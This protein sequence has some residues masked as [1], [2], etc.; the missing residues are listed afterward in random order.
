MFPFSDLDD[1]Q[2]FL[3]VLGKSDF[4]SEDVLLIPSKDISKFTTQC[5]TISESFEKDEDENFPVRIESKYYDIN[6]LNLTKPDLPS[7]FGLFHVNIASLN[8]H[9]DDLKLILSL[10]NYKFDVIG[11]SEHKI[12]KHDDPLAN[13]DIP[14]YHSFLFEPT[15]T[16][17]GGTGFYLK[18]NILFDERK[19]LAFNSATN[20]ESSFIEIKF[21][22]K[23][24]LIIGCIY[25]HPNSKI[26]IQEFN[27]EFIDPLLHK[28]NMENKQCILMGDFN[29][30]LLKSDTNGDTNDFFN[31]LSS[32]LF[33]PY[34]LQPTRLASKTLIDNI[35]F[36]SLEY[37]S[38]SGNLLI[39]IS[40]HLI[41]FLILEGFIREKNT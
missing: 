13:I 40:D 39:E 15:E 26:N 4:V 35:F 33:T 20:F 27:R 34:I 5:E 23:K 30:D 22:K 31:T 21:Q 9:I 12:K 1:N 11:I 16:T 38:Y 19:D 32:S 2:Y 41:Q 7:S 28:I 24:N 10:L 17:H 37:Q 18:D 8:A 29:I 14:G 6:Q 3:N 25:R 36:N